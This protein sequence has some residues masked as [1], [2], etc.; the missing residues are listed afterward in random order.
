MPRLSRRAKNIRRLT[1]KVREHFLAF[2]LR[3]ADSEEDSLE[4][5]RYVISLA[6]LEKA[7][8]QRYKHQMRA[9]VCR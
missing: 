4:D 6:E 8:S 5:D 7:E 1:K 3:S 9:R 2:L